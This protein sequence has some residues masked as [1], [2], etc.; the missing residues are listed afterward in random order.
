MVGFPLVQH[1]FTGFHHIQALMNHSHAVGGS[2]GFRRGRGGSGATE[3]GKQQQG[4]EVGGGF[5]GWF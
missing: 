3:I 2:F 1:G 5:D 4:Q